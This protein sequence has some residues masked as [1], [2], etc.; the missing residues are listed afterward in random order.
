MDAFGIHSQL[1]EDYRAFTSGFVEIRDRRLKAHVEERLE[2][3]AQWPAPWVSLNPSFAPGGQISDLVAEG[4]LHP[5]CDRIFRHKRDLTDPGT[6]GLS[7]RRHQREAVEAARDGSSY[8]LTTGTGSGK[9]LAYIV[10]IVDRLLRDK[11]AAGKRLPGVKAIVV[12]PMNALANSQ[13]HE[14]EKFLRFGYQAGQQPVTFARYT[15]QESEDERRKILADPPDLLLTNYVM[16]DLVL[17]RPDE[18]QHLIRAAQG[19]QFLVL[20]ELHTYRGRQ[21]AD[22]ALLVRRIRNACEAPHM[23]CV[24]TSATMASGGTAAQQRQVV[25]EV[26]SRLFGTDIAPDHV[27]GETLER[28]TAA[29]EPTSD[30]LRKRVTSAPEVWDYPSFVSDPLAAWVESTF[31]LHPDPDTRRLV[32]RKPDTVTNAADILAAASGESPAACASAIRDT[33]QAGSRVTD[34][35]TGR[36]VFAFRLH[37]FLSKGDNVY[38][39]LEP[40]DTRYIT[41][42]Y[43][44]VVPGHPDKVLLPLAFCRECGQEYVSVVA[45]SAEGRAR[46]VARMNNDTSGEKTGYFYVSSADDY[47][48]PDTAEHAINDGRLPDSWLSIGPDGDAALAPSVDKYLP[49]ILYVD[50]TGAETAPG[51]GLRVAYLPGRFRFCLRC[52]VSYEQVRGQDFGKLA[53]LSAEGRS[54]AMSIISA[55]VVRSLKAVTD[56]TFSPKAKKLLTFVDN[57]QDASLQAGHF[58]DFVQVV[59]LRGA[60]Y[61][62][63]AAHPHGIAHESIAQQ[64][65]EAIGLELPDFAQNPEAKF[66]ARD[67]AVRALREVINYRLYVDLQRGWRVTMPNLDLPELADDADSWSGCTHFLK[68]DSPEHRRELCRIILDELRRVLAIDVECL[69]EPGF[70]QIRKLSDQHLRDPWA[71]P[72]REQLPLIGA[73]FPRPGGKGQSRGDTFLSGRHAL[74]R[75]LRRVGQFPHISGSVT[76]DDAQQIIRDLLTVLERTGLLCPVEAPAGDGYRLKASAVLWKPG[77]GQTGADDPVRRTYHDEAGAR[78]NP[79]FRD[80]YRDVAA[81]LSGMHAREHTAQVPSAQREQRERDFSNATLPLLYCSPTMELGVDIADLN[82]VGLR[83]VPPT[84]ANYA[85]RSGRAGRAGHPALVVTYCA[86]GNA[87]DHYYFAH[88]DRMVA[89]SVAAPRLDLTNEDLLR[90]HLHAIWLAETGQSLGRTITSLLDVD[91]DEPTL[92]VREEV[93]KAFDAPDAQLRAG[94]RATDVLAG[95]MAELKATSWWH[96]TW[97]ADVIRNAPQSFD[98]ACDRWRTLYQAAAAEQRT[99]NRIARDL[100]TPKK[101][102][103]RAAARRREAETQMQLLC[104]EASG[105]T[106]SD[107]YSY[108]YFA[109]EGFLPGYSFP[110]LPLAAYIPG[111]RRTGGSDG[112]YL[113]R[114]RFL[115][116]R[117]F[118]PGALIYHEGA[119]YLV[120]RIQLPPAEHGQSAIETSEARVCEKCGY[121]HDR[122]VGVDICESCDARLETTIHNL[123]KL[124]TVFT[125]RR[126]RITSDEEERRRSGYELQVSYRFHDHG[127]RPGRIDAILSA[128]DDS[129][130]LTLTYGDSATIRVT[131]I[132][133]KRRK[134]NEGKGFWL[135]T[136]TGK[137]LSEKAGT[138]ELD[139][140]VDDVRTKQK[141]IPYVEDRRNILVT[142]LTEE[143]D[144]STAVSL[145]YALERGIEAAFQLEDSELAS[146][147]LPDPAHTGR[148]LFTESAEGGAGVLRRLVDEPG[149]LAKAA[150]EALQIAHFDPDTGDDTG[151]TDRTGE[152]CEKACYDCLLTFGNQL[153]H[154]LIDRHLVR[155]LLLRFATASASRGSGGSSRQEQIDT[156]LSYC[157]SD[158]ERRFVTWLAERELRLPDAAQETVDEAPARPDFTYRLPAGKVAVFIDGPHHDAATVALRDQAAEENLRDLGWSVIR[159]RHDADWDAIA[160]RHPSTF[161]T[162]ARPAL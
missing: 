79:F 155:D 46:F 122:Q 18:R 146:E 151:G 94:Q 97:I 57:R 110:R 38:V 8:V 53:T 73:V 33:L 2:S 127:A 56:P 103:E 30:Q 9:S 19:L 88:S 117:E 92:R 130:L 101:I 152:R 27:I 129:T 161:G 35:H 69:T 154:E 67:N 52:R 7:L 70:E 141:V 75:Y 77:G 124:Q 13:R 29:A 93:R 41:G 150:R 28:A 113:Q 68:S 58:N 120:D 31:G 140:T 114:P 71:M 59:Q 107:F 111:N 34:P 26:A 102:K 136:N 159:L 83:N 23:Q 3:G 137:W 55:S 10:P 162:G 84:P 134:D 81:T 156:L 44:T 5:E 147:A 132:G 64:V 123:L 17:T 48:W 116:I 86:T 90:S 61:R 15:G 85:Q 47:P 100:S 128:P 131:N 149:A 66:S 144:E 108:R 62:A 95:V 87:H 42:R 11:E 82:A 135:D 24:G 14:L 99:Q 39:S 145:G 6:V 49:K 50:A 112:D 121:L 37:Q 40:E 126:E 118:G 148:T 115:A 32:R 45:E 109:S 158:L 54:S 51:E 72:D 25:A 76:T 142:R 63:V 157:E 119:R 4:L 1:I 160:A 21:G 104:N 16:L 106:H 143:V 74:G 60:L 96:D 12:Y 139:T 138:D 105:T 80:L 22:V 78:V 91:G 65:T 89:G 133:R 43:Q 36:P 98:A 20:D 125:R 153:Q